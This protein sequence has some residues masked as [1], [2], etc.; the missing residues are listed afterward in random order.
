MREHLEMDT[1]SDLAEKQATELEESI[2]AQTRIV[3]ELK[4][5]DA[6][7]A[8]AFLELLLKCRDDLRRPRAKSFG[9]DKPGS[10][11]PR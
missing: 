6:T 2:A 10:R 7:T 4:D 5:Q 8:Q 3:Q 11:R 9:V 1:D